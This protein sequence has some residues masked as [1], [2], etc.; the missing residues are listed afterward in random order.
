MDNIIII[1]KVITGMRPN[2]FGMDKGLN[3]F[4]KSLSKNLKDNLDKNLKENGMDYR[5]SI[6]HTYDSIANLIQNNVKLV[7]ISPYVKDHINLN[8]IN[9]NNYYILREK[10]FND[11]YVKDIIIYLKKVNNGKI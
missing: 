3:I 7:L 9:K 1:S 2:P 8:N 6:D 4:K 11:R 5:V 10:E